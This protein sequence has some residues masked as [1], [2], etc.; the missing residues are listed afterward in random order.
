MA[1]Y[2]V[3]IGGVQ[4]EFL[5]E[6]RALRDF[7]R[8]DPLLGR[9]FDLFLFEDVAASD[10]H[11]DDLYLDEVRRCDVYVGL[12]SEDYG[13]EAAEGVSPT[14]REFDEATV[15]GSHRLIFVKGVDA[16]IRHPKMQ[17]LIGKA[18]AGLIRKHFSTTQE[19]LTG[20]YAALVGYLDIAKRI[21]WGPFEASICEG[22]TLD[23]LDSDRMA[24]FVQ[25]ARGARGFPLAESAAPDQLLKHL[26]L[27]SDG[28]PTNAAVLLFG[29]S[30]QR[31]L[32]SSEIKC[33]HFHG[34]EVAKPIPSLQVY[35]GT[36]FEL[37]DQAVDFVL[38]KIARSVG[39]R[40]HSVQVPIT[41]EI[42]VEVITEAIVNAVAHRDYTSNGSVQ[43]MLFSDR[44]E[45]WNPGRLPPQLTL[46]KLRTAHASVPTNRLLAQSLYLAKYIEQMGT[47]TLDMIRRCSA[48]GLAEP[49]FTVSD[50]FAVTVRR[51]VPESSPEPPHKPSDRRPTNLTTK[52]IAMLKACAQT[53][54][55]AAELRAAA[56]YASRTSAF[57]QRLERLLKDGLLGMTFADKPSSSRQRYEITPKGT[58]VL[59]QSGIQVESRWSPSGVQVIEQHWPQASVPIVLDAKDSA[60]LEACIQGSATSSELRMA[61]GYASRTSAFRQRL[62]RLVRNELLELTVPDRP[63]SRSQRYRLT[64]KGRAMLA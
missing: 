19:L 46:E 59:T 44:L 11:P 29:K 20:L 30:T 52:E 23:D 27:L 37:V 51:A 3:F 26:H 32:L 7:L 33:A 15:S 31:F 10:R 56:G 60:M 9:F 25:A 34:T 53:S 35:R 50:G 17:A 43:V 4:K 42:P 21:R 18:Q 61:S 49:E 28:R 62:E 39:T 22:A 55:T 63:R 64:A 45:V 12:F 47:G 16:E 36:A 13:S 54:A 5:G 41:Y 14:E 38:S 6:R 1:S 58:A 8:S 57:R 2:R 40:A 24:R 48:A